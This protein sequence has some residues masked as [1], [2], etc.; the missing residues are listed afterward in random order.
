MHQA[1]P[2]DMYCTVVEDGVI[3][4]LID[5]LS[6]LVHLQH[7]S[8]RCLWQVDGTA[9]EY[10]LR[11]FSDVTLPRLKHLTH[12]TLH[13]VNDRN[14]LQ[15]QHLSSLS[16]L[17]LKSAGDTAVG[18]HS[19]PGMRF[20]ASLQSLF[21][22]SPAEAG[23]LSLFPPGLQALRVYNGV[24]GP[25]EVPSAIL[26]CL[27]RLQNLTELSLWPGY[28]LDW[29]PA[30]PIYA[31]LTA[32]SCLAYLEVAAINW[33]ESVWPH[34]VS[35]AL[36]NLTCLK[37]ASRDDEDDV[38]PMPLLGRSD[39]IRLVSCCPG[40]C[41]IQ[42]LPLKPGWYVSL[43]ST[44]TALTCVDAYVG[45]DD[46]GHLGRCLTGFADVT[47]LRSLWVILDSQAVKMA[48]MLPLTQLTNL[49]KLVWACTGEDDDD[50]DD[51]EEYAG[52]HPHM[53]FISSAEVSRLHACQQRAGCRCIGRLSSASATSIL[54]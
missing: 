53:A 36:P 18:P 51:E 27:A 45:P 38:L 50:G 3:D 33:P 14:L 6:S 21:L 35:A 15:L 39:F 16:W 22:W 42:D 34:V 13:G 48:S 11:G 8:V 54:G 5:S 20:P 43:L 31:A 7:L 17:L 47:Q 19:V 28:D 4:R 10:T 44:L 24:E 30:G 46:V 12:L 41:E 40:L 25:G 32:S 52:G 23:L 9:T 1:D 49:T 29:P 37:I 26:A 2:L